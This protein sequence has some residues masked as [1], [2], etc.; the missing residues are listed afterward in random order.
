MNTIKLM[1]VLFL[2]ALA[3]DDQSLFGEN[4]FAL[5]PTLTYYQDI[6]DVACFGQGS[7]LEVGLSHE[8]EL[9][10][11]TFAVGGVFV[12]KSLFYRPRRA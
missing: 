3:L 7:W 8:F 12:R 4:W 2:I 9:A 10:N 6:D 1:T 11:P 5:N